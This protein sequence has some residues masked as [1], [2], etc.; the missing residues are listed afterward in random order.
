MKE[1]IK[2]LLCEGERSKEL[3]GEGV[4]VYERERRREIVCVKKREAE[5]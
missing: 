1:R 3:M 5:S 2:E 4:C